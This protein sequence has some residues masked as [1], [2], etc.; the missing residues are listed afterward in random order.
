MDGPDAVHDIERCY[1]VTEWTLK[2]VF[3]ELYVAHVDAR[4][5]WC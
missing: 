2:T 5:A 4:A 3:Q 1:E